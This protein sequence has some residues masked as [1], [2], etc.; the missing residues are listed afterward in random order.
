MAAGVIFMQWHNYIGDKD[1]KPFFSEDPITFNTRQERLHKLAPG[2]RLWLVSR[3]PDDGQYYF[4]TALVIAQLTRNPPGSEKATVFG[5]YAILADPSQSRDLGR[6]FPA[7]ALLR[8]F[9]FETAR[10]IKYGASIGK[11][12]QSLRLLD[13]GDECVLNAALDVILKGE[14]PPYV[15]PCG[16]WTKCD[17]VFA[18][19]FLKNW[20]RRH[21]PLAFLLYDPP[22]SL[23]AGSP[24]FTHADKSLR[25]LA[26][27]R[28][29]QFV[30]GHKM[31]V[32]AEERTPERE[33]IWQ[34]HRV[35]TIDPPTKDEFDK[36]WEGQNG[37]RGLFIMDDIGE[38][39]KPVAFKT[40]GRALEWGFPMGVGYRYLS[41]AQS[42]LLLR[43][44]T[45]P[46]EV[47]DKCLRAILEAA[48]SDVS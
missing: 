7:E 42:L 25:L 46:P 20:T 14:S 45:M 35:N 8:A 11:S 19:Y 37:V 4:I 13:P 17:G 6:R 38:L 36:F 41:L 34:T 43:L 16:L 27:F 31:T 2:D 9:A 1:G 15:T 32:E 22:P 44:A 30:A 26:R 48:G 12:L 40:Y 23:R 28:Q 39:P 10:P 47:N 21:E 18:D 29:G 5:E 3:S 24:V 33:R